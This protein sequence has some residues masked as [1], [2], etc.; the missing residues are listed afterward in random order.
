[1]GTFTRTRYT[2]EILSRKST[3]SNPHQTGNLQWQIYTKKKKKKTFHIKFALALFAADNPQPA[4][5]RLLVDFIA[6]FDIP[7]KVNR[8][9]LQYIQKP[10]TTEM[11][12]LWIKNLHHKFLFP[13]LKFPLCG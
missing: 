1:M 4:A 11:V 12:I 5:I 7:V 6:D 3:L 13:H 10:F 9:N 2:A 8:E